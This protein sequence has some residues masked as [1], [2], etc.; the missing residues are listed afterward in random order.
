[1]FAGKKRF[2]EEAAAMIPLRFAVRRGLAVL[3]AVLG[4]ASASPAAEPIKIGFSMALTGG[5]AVNGKATLAAMQIWE[6][7]I[8]AKGGL[9]GRPVKLVYYDDQSNPSTVPGIYTKLL[10][11]DHVDL[12]VGGYATVMLAPAMPVIMQH[13][14]TFL[15]FYGLAV[16]AEFHYPRYFALAPTGPHPKA[17]FTK[18]FFDLAMAQNPKPTRLAIIAADLEFSKNAAE[19]GRENA[20]AA[21]LSI[22]YDESFPG[23]TADCAPIVR[24]IQ[25]ANPDIVLVATYPP[26]SVCMLRAVNEVGF[27]PKL[28]GGAMVGLQATAIKQQLGPLLNGVVTYDFWLPT[29]SMMFPGVEEVLKKYQAEAPSLGVDPLGYYTVPAAYAYLQ[30][31]GQ[32]VEIAKSLDQDKLAEVLHKTTFK[33]AFGD[34]AFGADGEWTQSRIL[35]VQFVGI[36]GND[37]DQFRDPKKTVVLD[38]P[39]YRSG[40]LIYPYAV[41]LT[42]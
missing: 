21:G 10:D 14:M 2:G 34:I 25:A 32:A 9:L 24:A 18:G 36:T 17:S 5:L 1:M 38:P 37:L 11:V 3:G 6:A 7:D 13:D 20:K 42:H 12:V 8:N 35:T 22:V 30:V 31:L 23:N 4:M 28:I 39:Q 26:S 41:A 33:T 27:R 29:P 19:G 40:T 16:N 15:G